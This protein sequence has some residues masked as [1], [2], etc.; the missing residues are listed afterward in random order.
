MG[1]KAQW[2]KCQLFVKKSD[3][4]IFDFN[5]KIAIRLKFWNWKFMNLLRILTDLYQCAHWGVFRTLFFPYA[6]A[7]VLALEFK[8]AKM[9]LEAHSSIVLE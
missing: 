6:Y 2:Y 9:Q 3:P 7:I 4:E 1:P 5:L 8:A